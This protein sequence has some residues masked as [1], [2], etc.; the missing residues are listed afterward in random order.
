[1]YKNTLYKLP[2]DIL[3]ELVCKIFDNISIKELGELYKKKC[4][5]KIDKYKEILTNTYHIEDLEIS[6][7][8]GVISV[9]TENF[10]LKIDIVDYTIADKNDK[11]FS[12]ENLQGLLERIHTII[13]ERFSEDKII[14]IINSIQTIITAYKDKKEVKK[15]IINNNLYI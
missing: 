7:W 15:F 12:C 8:R 11:W 4:I 2:K 10:H 3:I 14:Q 1:M 5:D 6:F 9:T 13:S